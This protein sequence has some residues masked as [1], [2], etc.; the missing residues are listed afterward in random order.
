MWLLVAGLF[1]FF[2]VHLL[3]TTDRWRTRLVAW[4]GEDIY[5]LGFSLTAAAGLVLAGYG[6]SVAPRILFYDPPAWTAHLSWLL[7]W[8]AVTIFPAAYMPS[9]L[10]RFMRHP[11]LWGVTLWALAHLL[12]NGDLA[13][14]LLF[15]S[16]AVYA[17]YDMRSANRRGAALS[18]VRQPVWQDG[19]LVAVGLLAYVILIRLH[20]LL[21][22]V[23]VNPA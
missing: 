7:M 16:F 23:S 14:I 3:P 20:P 18:T 9:N 12:T 15:G 17:M 8:L 2:A 21:F 19:L 6:K 22:G 10:K 5:K 11:F 1:V 13:S 4:K